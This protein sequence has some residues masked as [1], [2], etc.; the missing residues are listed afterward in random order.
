M[1]EIQQ[2]V[3]KVHR[4]NFRKFC[5]QVSHGTERRTEIEMCWGKVTTARQKIG[6]GSQG[7]LHGPGLEELLELR[8][9]LAPE[10]GS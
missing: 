3:S 4:T 2:V 1:T 8:C 9:L 5:V 6:R 10:A 7:E